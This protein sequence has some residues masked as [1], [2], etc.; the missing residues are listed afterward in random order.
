M[1]TAVRLAWMKAPTASANQTAGGSLPRPDTRSSHVQEHR[2][3]PGRQPARRI[4]QPEAR[5]GHP[6]ERARAG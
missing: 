5:R 2:T 6:A 3:Y 1:R 4:H